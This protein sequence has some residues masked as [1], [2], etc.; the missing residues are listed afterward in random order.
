MR[1]VRPDYH[2]IGRDWEGETAFIVGG[3][4]SVLS[5][6]IETIH[7]RRV[8]VINSSYETVPFADYLIYHDEQWW[9][10]HR[11]LV[12]AFRGII[13]N[14][15]KT[16]QKCERRLFARKA[17][18]PGLARDPQSLT[19]F[20]TTFTAAINLAVHLGASRI[21]LLGA[22]GK[23]GADG[24]SHHHAPHTWWKFNTDRWDKHR[25]ELATLIEPLRDLGIDV[26]NA[27]PGTA[28]DMW[29]VM[30]LKDAIL[31]DARDALLRLR[32][33]PTDLQCAGLP[34]AGGALAQGQGDRAA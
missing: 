15:T 2:R 29:P 7:G 8:I 27:S 4:T 5:Q 13:I 32:A 6:D 34:D 1:L 31:H 17:S 22:D 9:R 16:R 18:P 14:V 28:W 26:V 33:E 19:M 23:M 3:G 12:S 24:R 10:K 11:H 20:R 25:A 30:T 21:V